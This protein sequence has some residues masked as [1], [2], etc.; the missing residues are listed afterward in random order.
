[1]IRK[2]FVFAAGFAVVSATAISQQ[3]NQAADAQEAMNA[4]GALFGGGGSTNAT[5]H[6]RQLKELLPAEFKGTKRSASESGKNAAFGM[7]ISYAQ[8]D[9]TVGDGQITVK[10]SDISAM[11][12]FM[13]M[14]QFAWTQS[15][16]ER[17]TDTGYE[18]STHIDG[19]AA[20]EKYESDTKSGQIQV[21]VDDR[22][23]VEV[24]GN[25][26]EMDDMKALI[27]AVGLKR[28]AALKPE[29]N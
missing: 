9:Y 6:F 23:M 11:G 5:V 18:R 25:G 4:L 26:V 16:I 2:C 7:N 15:E 21:M 10:I 12:Q 17:E 14:A 13:K 1:M 3:Q 19:F 27:D 20:Q 22:F 28:L 24:N 29:T 8:A